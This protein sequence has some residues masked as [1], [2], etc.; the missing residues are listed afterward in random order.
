[1]LVCY[2]QSSLKPKDED[3]S[4]LMALMVS[5]VDA[6]LSKWVRYPENRQ[7]LTDDRVLRVTTPDSLPSIRTSE[8]EA[9]CGNTGISGRLNQG[10]CCLRTLIIENHN[11]TYPSREKSRISGICLWF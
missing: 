2:R 4:E 3:P 11:N 1:M 5:I 6:R 8:F 10:Q 7:V 9:R